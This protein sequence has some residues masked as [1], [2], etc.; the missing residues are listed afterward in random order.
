MSKDI[1]QFVSECSVC[2]AHSTSQQKEPLI[3]HEVTARPWQKIGI[4]IFTLNQRDFLITVDYF[5]NYFEVDRLRDKTAK[6][7]IGK[8]KP[9][10]ARHGILDMTMTD[11]GQPFGSQEFSC[12]AETYGFEHLTSSPLYPQSNGKVEKAVHT[13]K[14]DHDKDLSE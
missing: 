5:S 8:L 4:D 6:E 13:A 11:N 10:L 9:H 12:F 3:S 1:E 2:N 7:V 14:K